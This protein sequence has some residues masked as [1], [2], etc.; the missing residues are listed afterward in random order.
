MCSGTP[1]PLVGSCITTGANNS[2]IDCIEFTGSIFSTSSINSACSGTGLMSSTSPCPAMG[3]V[4]GHCIEHC[5]ASD[6]DVVYY[7]TSSGLDSTG[8]Q[9][10]CGMGGGHWVP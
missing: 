8:A 10:A 5:G 2:I 1:Q 6:E 4:A 9:N 3:Q 7:Y